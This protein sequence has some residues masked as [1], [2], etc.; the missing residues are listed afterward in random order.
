MRATAFRVVAAAVVF[1]A[2]QAAPATAQRV[3]VAA[4]GSDANPC[5]FAL[6]CRTFQH[7]HDTVAAG[8]EID[9]LDPAG[10]GALTIN[11]AIS[12]QG[13]GFS[14]L[15]V[16]SGGTGIFIAAGTNDAIN[17]NGL[18]I[19]GS[20]VGNAGIRWAS[21]KS[22]V[23]A[24]CIIRNT[25]FNG[26]IFSSSATTAQTLSIADSSISDIGT[27]GIV[28]QTLSSGAI[29]AAIDRVS[30]YGNGAVGLDVNGT[31]GTGA[32][33]V[34]VKDSVAAH[35]SGFGASGFLVHSSAGHSVASLVL[36][37]VKAT[38]N[39]TGI[40]ADGTNATMRLAQSAVTG[41]AHGFVASSGGTIL[42]YGDNTLDDNGSNTG[43]LGSAT[44]Q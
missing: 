41:N 24:N 23:V 28:V 39:D 12:I 11:K 9:V 25:L 10:Y 16:A 4:Q 26:L 33:S 40:A 7:A 14:G 35:S 21:G 18:L 3:F 29:T 34:A 15:S 8:G 37:R 44:K 32:L 6:P 17:L 31:G 27:N 5:T 1:V 20:G 19:E 22:L 43:S 36:S 30:L 2:L 38:G 42:S 13:H